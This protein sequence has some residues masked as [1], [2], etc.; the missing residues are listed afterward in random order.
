LLQQVTGE[1]ARLGWRTCFILS[2]GITNFTLD[3]LTV[4]P[5]L[6]HVGELV[7]Q[8]LL[9][10][11]ATRL[12]SSRFEKNVPALGKG[13]RPQRS[14]EPISPGVGMDPDPT[15]VSVKGLFKG[16]TLPLGDWLTMPLFLGNG[17]F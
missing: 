15:K 2:R 9:P 5:L 11:M 17:G 12:V 4:G 1:R 8:Q 13:D 3:S 7:G 14:T 16:P 10:P 6:N